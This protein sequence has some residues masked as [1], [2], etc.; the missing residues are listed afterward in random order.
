MWHSAGSPSKRMFE[1]LGTAPMTALLQQ[2]GAEYD[3]A[4][5][6]CAPAIVA[7]DA[8]SLAQRCDASI[9]VTRALAETRGM[10]GRV[11][12]EFAD[13][14]AVLLGIVVNAVRS[15]A[16]GY[17]KRNIRTSAEYHAHD[18]S[19]PGPNTAPKK[20]EPVGSGENSA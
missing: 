10:V 11:K 20:P 1:R 8:S 4:F 6:D 2:A 17:M 12:N 5:L 19:G 16:G 15:A 14:P 3:V 7:G 18:Q 9:L 13:A